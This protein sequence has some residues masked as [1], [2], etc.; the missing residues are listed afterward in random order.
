MELTTGKDDRV[1]YVL[2]SLDDQ[3]ALA[4]AEESSLAT[5]RKANRHP[6]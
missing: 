4:G 2:D 1:V 5:K 6:M 3:R